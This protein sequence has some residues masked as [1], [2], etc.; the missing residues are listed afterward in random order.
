MVPYRPCTSESIQRSASTRPSKRPLAVLLAA[1]R[2]FGGAM[3]VLLP[4]RLEAQFGRRRL[5]GEMHHD[6]AARASVMM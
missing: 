5:V 1:R 4:A 3:K 6:A 2:I